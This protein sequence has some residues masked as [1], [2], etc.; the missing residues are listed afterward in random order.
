MKKG[1]QEQ[2][3]FY[4]KKNQSAFHASEWAQLGDTIEDALD[5]LRRG[6]IHFETDMPLSIEFFKQL[7][8]K[9]EIRS[10]DKL[11]MNLLQR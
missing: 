5:N 4:G 6:K 2:N 1:W 8:T 10:Y 7:P 11:Q 9:K 3:A